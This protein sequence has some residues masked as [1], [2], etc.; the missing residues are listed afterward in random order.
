[1]KFKDKMLRKEKTKVNPLPEIVQASVHGMF[2]C[3]NPEQRLERFDRG[4][5]VQFFGSWPGDDIKPFCWKVYPDR[6]TS[7]SAIQA[8]RQRGRQ[9]G[10][11]KIGIVAVFPP[12][13]L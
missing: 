9:Y 4:W 8:I 3:S 10:F 13:P 11:A 12:E 6:P 7:E 5:L 1:M 2:V